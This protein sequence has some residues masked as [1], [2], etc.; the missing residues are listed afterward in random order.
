MRSMGAIRGHCLLQIGLGIVLPGS[1]I[2][3]LTMATIGVQAGEDHPPARDAGGDAFAGGTAD[4]GSPDDGPRPS[5]LPCSPDGGAEGD[6]RATAPPADGA[7]VEPSNSPTVEATLPPAPPIPAPDS[8]STVPE[9]TATLTTAAQH[10]QRRRLGHFG[11]GIDVGISGVLPDVGLLLVG[12]PARWGHLQLGVGYN[13]LAP[14]IRGGLTLINPFVI[15]VSFTWEAGHYFEGDANRAVHWVDSSA[16]SNAALERFGYDYMNLLGGLSIGDGDFAFHLRFGVT[17]MRTT[18]HGFEQSVRE[19]T[20]LNLTASDPTV[21]YRG[22]ALKV[23]FDY[24][25]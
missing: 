25:L 5:D 24:F 8:T 22:P 23:G 7:A 6:S 13:G 9:T 21:H 10:V 17:W 19:A 15:P 14:G 1:A 16:Q 4:A 20:E 11:M 2:L 3:A 12:R 18:I